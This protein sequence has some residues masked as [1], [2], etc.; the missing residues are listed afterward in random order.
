MLKQNI[1][2]YKP[3]LP[4]TYKSNSTL[5]LSDKGIYYKVNYFYCQIH[6]LSA[7]LQRIIL[8]ALNL[9]VGWDYRA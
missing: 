3:I 7:S 8:E 9:N 6:S 4:F 2:D 5:Y 1:F